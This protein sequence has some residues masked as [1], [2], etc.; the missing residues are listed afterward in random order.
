MIEQIV[1]TRIDTMFGVAGMMRRLLNEAI[2]HT[3]RRSAFGAPLA[4]QPAMVNVLA[5][6]ALE[7][8]AAAQA[9]FRV[10]RAFDEGDRTFGRMALAVMKY[11]VC[12]RGAP[13]AAEALECLGGNGYIETQQ[14]PVA[15]FYRDIQIGTVW[16]GSGNVIALD[17]LRAMAREPESVGGFML[18]CESARGADRRLD[19]HLD[20]TRAALDDL[21]HTEP[22]FAA[23]ALV[24]DMALALQGALLVRNGP[25]HV[26]DAF[27]AARLE[28][29]HRAFGTLRAGSDAASLVERAL[30]Q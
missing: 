15:Q 4:T 22:Q 11:W 19:A 26:A 28:G 3:R 1:W 5:D 14:A 27:C 9:S 23:R 8:E 21:A 7:T 13:F 25:A 6:L 18:E 12:K 2:W 17:V 29:R 30:P 10:A 16:E 20:A 24:E